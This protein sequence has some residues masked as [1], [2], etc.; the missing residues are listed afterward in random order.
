MSLFRNVGKAL[1]SLLKFLGQQARQAVWQLQ[2]TWGR[3]AMSVLSVPEESSPSPSAAQAPVQEPPEHSPAL[4][5]APAPK[6]SQHLTQE[7]ALPSTSRSYV[8]QRCL[9]L[10]IWI[11][12]SGWR[13]GRRSCITEQ[14][15]HKAQHCPGKTLTFIIWP[16]PQEIKHSAIF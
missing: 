7:L 1:K 2:P 4:L 8:A 12:P 6:L 10:N 14:P 9:L 3:A 11:L 5:T 16:S 13:A 15:F